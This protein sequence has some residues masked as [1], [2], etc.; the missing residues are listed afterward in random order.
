M[1][2][3]SDINS[4][5]NTAN[6]ATNTRSQSPI[7]KVIAISQ[8][9]LIEEDAVRLRKDDEEAVRERLLLDR[10][11]QSFARKTLQWLASISSTTPSSQPFSCK[12]KEV[13]MRKYKSVGHRYLGFCWEAYSISHELER[14]RVLSSYDGGFS[15]GFSSDEDEYPDDNC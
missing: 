9:R 6:A 4:I 12:G 2:K 8:T 11:G 13:S 1:S 15:S 10:L 3:D 14:D 5:S 7:N